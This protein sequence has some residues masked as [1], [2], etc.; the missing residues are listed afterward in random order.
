MN[1]TYIILAHNDPKHLGRLV[2]ALYAD[3]VMF[4]IHIDSRTDVSTFSECFTMLD[5]RSINFVEE[6]CPSGWGS[7]YIIEATLNCLKFVYE[8]LPST[9]RIILMSGSDYPI[10]NNKYIHAYLKA[11]PMK[12]YL[13]FNKVPYTIWWKGGK[14]RF[15]GF[16]KINEIMKIY[17]GSQWFSLP[18]YALKIIFDFLD[19]N[20]NFLDYFREVIIPDESF[21]QTLFLNCGEKIVEENLINRNLHLIKWDFPYGHPR[22]FSEKHFNLIKKTDFLFARKFNTETPS[23]VLD[24]I[25]LEL[26]SRGPQIQN[27]LSLD[28]G[29]QKCVVLFL[30]NKNDSSTLNA[31]HS[32]K[33]ETTNCHDVY[34]LYHQ[35]TKRLPE[36][37]AIENPILFNDEIL[38]SIGFISIY[39]KLVPGS[40]HFP[41]FMY[42]KKEPEYDY[43]WYIEDDVRFNGAW[44]TFFNSIK[45][46]D[47]NAD[48]LT[49]HV[50]QYKDE[51]YWFWWETLKHRTGKRVA[52]NLRLR[53][54]NPI[55]RISK[56]ALDFLNEA[57]LSG[58]SGHHEVTMAS[59]LVS[60]G[61]S[62]SDL[63]DVGEFVLQK[64]TRKYYKSA[65][66]DNN[67]D[68][69]TGSV[70]FRPYIN[71]SE[72]TEELLYHP[73][74]VINNRKKDSQNKNRK[75]KT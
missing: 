33:R 3:H 16:E 61:F 59:L 62:I 5:M 1:L 41:L 44:D 17:A 28:K 50:R 71:S 74:K 58:W 30:T 18:N 8:K 69:G 23:K 73:V 72:M 2:N 4:V 49:C 42:F 15:P 46:N 38:Q 65:L 52:L 22:F 48:F 43:Y 36:S 31:Y 27:K 67:G 19:L 13:D 37:I 7:F 9:D 6:R 20:P 45:E 57:Y 51:P 55:F 35:T 56:R 11:N 39:D 53:S 34:L 29:Q 14:E 25:D 26:L 75:H 70:R 64:S 47:N 24:K 12:I 68:V 63:G 10:K 66:P 32:L 21:F 60:A 40:N 54:F